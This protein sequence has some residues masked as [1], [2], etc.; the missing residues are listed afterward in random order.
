MNI[1]AVL[2]FTLLIHPISVEFT[3]VFMHGIF[4]MALTLGLFIGLKFKGG[5]TK[6]FAGI[7]LLIY[8]IFIC[9]NFQQGVEI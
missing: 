8:I 3:T 1:V 4:M 6:Y 2:G 7:L 9:F 5:I